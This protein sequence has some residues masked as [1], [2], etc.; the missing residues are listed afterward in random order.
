MF[1]YYI[2]QLT[3]QFKKM[4]LM[5]IADCRHIRDYE[6]SSCQKLLVD[7]LKECQAYMR[8]QRVSKQKMNLCKK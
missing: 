5:Q 2:L 1:S 7:V 6:I 4:K 8:D 3:V